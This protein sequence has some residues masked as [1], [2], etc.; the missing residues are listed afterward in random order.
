MGVR[1]NT[2]S[3]IPVAAVL[4][5]DVK[6]MLYPAG[7]SSNKLCILHTASTCTIGNMRL[8][9]LFCV[10]IASLNNVHVS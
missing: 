3:R 5:H 2:S 4:Y 8:M 7:E 1:L 6:V 10:N 9:V